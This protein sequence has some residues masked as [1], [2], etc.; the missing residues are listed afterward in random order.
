MASLGYGFVE[1]YVTQKLYKEKL[2]KMAHQERQQEQQE[3]GKNTMKSNA[4][5]K[6]SEDKTS[7]GCFFFLSKQ[8]RR[9][10]S[11]ISDSPDAAEAAN[12]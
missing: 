2:A 8:Q 5:S 11:Q 12:S 4:T 3:E 7:G 9:K 6:A 1:A 10:V